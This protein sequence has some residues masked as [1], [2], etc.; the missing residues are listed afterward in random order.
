MSF[1]KALRQAKR[2]AR[3]PRWFAA[4]GVRKRPKDLLTAAYLAPLV[5]VDTRTKEVLMI[6]PRATMP[7]RANQ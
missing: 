4:V 1:T 5:T 6:T 3:A 7:R 2:P